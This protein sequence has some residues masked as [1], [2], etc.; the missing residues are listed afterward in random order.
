MPG[1]VVLKAQG[2]IQ[3]HRPEVQTELITKAPQVDLPRP[4]PRQELY[5]LCVGHRPGGKQSMSILRTIKL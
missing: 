5:D 2:K 3:G 4:L 1:K